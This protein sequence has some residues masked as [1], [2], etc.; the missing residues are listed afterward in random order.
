MK[1][2]INK[3]LVI[4]TI[5]IGIM[6]VKSNFAYADT[7]AYYLGSK[8]ATKATGYNQSKDSNGNNIEAT[9]DMSSQ[10]DKMLYYILTYE[11]YDNKTYVGDSSLLNL[12]ERKQAAIYYLV[13]NYKQ[14]INQYSNFTSNEKLKAIFE[15]YTGSGNNLSEF[16]DKT[17][18]GVQVIYGLS[19]AW[20]KGEDMAKAAQKLKINYKA[21]SDENFKYWA[22]ITE[23]PLEGSIYNPSS[24]DNTLIVTVYLP[25]EEEKTAQNAIKVVEKE[26]VEEKKELIKSLLTNKGVII[27]SV[28]K[29]I[30]TS[31]I[32]PN[33][34]ATQSV[35]ANDRTIKLSNGKTITLYEPVINAKD[36]ELPR[37]GKDIIVAATKYLGTEYELDGQE[38]PVRDEPKGYV[39]CSSMVHFTLKSLKYEF[40]NTGYGKLYNTTQPPVSGLHFLEYAKNSYL[41]TV[42]EVGI[43][44]DKNKDKIYENKFSNEWAEYSIKDL[45][46]GITVKSNGKESKVNILKVNDIVDKNLRYYEYYDAKWSKKEIPEGTIMFSYS[47]DGGSQGSGYNHS[48]IYIGDLGVSTAKDAIPILKERYGKDNIK[49]KYVRGSEKTESNST[50]WRIEATAAQYAKDSK[51]DAG[52]VVISNEDPEEYLLEEGDGQISKKAGSMWA[53]QVAKSE[54]SIQPKIKVIKV[55]QDEKVIT[56]K[57][58]KFTV[59]NSKDKYTAKNG[60]VEFETGIYEKTLSNLNYGGSD[61]INIEETHAPT[62]YNIN[63][64]KV[65]V[66]YSC[67]DKGVLSASVPEKTKGYKVDVSGTTIIVTVTDDIKTIKPKVQIKKVNKRDNKILLDGFKFKVGTYERITGESGASTGYTKAVEL[68]TLKW[69]ENGKIIIQ[70]TDAKA[71]YKINNKNSIELTY[72][73]ENG[74]LT[75]SLNSDKDYFIDP[76]NGID[77]KNNVI[78]VTVQDTQIYNLNITKVNANNE[79]QLIP[80]VGFKVSDG[81][82]NKIND[83]NKKTGDGNK[84]KPLG[85]I[86]YSNIEITQNSFNITIKETGTKP[87]NL[88][89]DYEGEI[90]IPITVDQK[91]GTISIKDTYKDKTNGI[92]DVKVSKDGH[93]I[94]VVVKDTPY[95]TPK[96][97]ITK[98]DSANSNTKLRWCMV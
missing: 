42:K 96:L 95:I 97:K 65:T 32:Q 72:G 24:E 98:V 70:E 29:L 59:G 85:K 39:D 52:R 82:N 44:Q 63:S 12:E 73:Y 25:K 26:I 84:S 6:I 68:G 17:R 36:S 4:F 40:R 15:N 16:D 90:T 51:G 92:Y 30:D 67:N 27:G 54:Q 91:A 88:T 74:K 64:N 37:S 81:D 3:L 61:S 34:I 55:D 78:T 19:E 14:N 80:N 62:G 77:Q 66:S 28:N 1:D 76:K 13:H 43:W 22:S 23:E 75:A 8:D 18:N 7:S 50:H 2:K 21:L 79:K 9:L 5:I 31:K 86:I 20:A 53:F 48:W 10:L 60:F 33:S 83:T 35:G 45:Y 93:T 58:A 38:Y 47:T 11:E 41:H 56:T 57:D 46:D 89:I 69:E 71:G 49:E 94:N 87:N